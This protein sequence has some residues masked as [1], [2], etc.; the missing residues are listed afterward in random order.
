MEPHSTRRQAPDRRMSSMASRMVRARKADCEPAV[1]PPEMKLDPATIV[2]APGGDGLPAAEM[3]GKPSRY[4]A[5]AS[6]YR[7]TSHHSPLISV[8]RYRGPMTC[9]YATGLP[10]K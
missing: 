10:A 8:G 4:G 1:A 5:L 9:A 3:G 2:F 6:S 7:C